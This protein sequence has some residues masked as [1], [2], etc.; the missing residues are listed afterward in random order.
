MS[1]AAMLYAVVEN[2][3]SKTIAVLQGFVLCQY[4][5]AKANYEA[6]AW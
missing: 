2:G 5:Q 1:R 4:V 3:P 6:W